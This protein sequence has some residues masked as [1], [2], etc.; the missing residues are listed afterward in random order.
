V[1]LPAPP[2][3]R[4]GLHFGVLGFPVRI[5]VSFVVVMALLGV[6]GPTTVPRVVLWVLIGAVSVLAHELGH[7]VVARTTGARPVIDLH[8][9]GGVTTF[10][11]PGPLS[12]GRSLAISVAGPLVGIAVG[13][14]LLV[15]VPRDAAG[16]SLTGYALD[17]AVFVNLGW[18]VLNL[19][20]I[21]PLDGGHA[22]AEL[23]PGDPEA[24]VRRAAFVSVPVA[25]AV[26]LF[27]LHEDYLFGALLAG[28]FAFDNVRT[29]AATNRAAA[30]PFPP[31]IGSTP[32]AREV[33]WLVD[34][35]RPDQA[36]HLL[37]TLP[38]DRPVDVAVHGLVLALTGR[39]EQGAPL[40]RHAHAQAP[41]DP[42]RTAVL[43][44]LLAAER[45]WDALGDLLDRV[46]HAG[47]AGGADGAAAPEVVPPEVV[48]AAQAAAAR[49]G[50]ARAAARL[51]GHLRGEPRPAA[52][53]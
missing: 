40:V 48:A 12:R 26:A 53:P 21:L 4:S 32:A 44:R 42:L 7:A 52:S 23:L 29:L 15:L 16:G 13:L 51:A 30:E 50:A 8:S 20:P 41:D 33:L 10:S 9:F 3:G 17:A 38:A 22:L 18:G 31:P 49:A 35:G 37:A 45:D 1:T 14:A 34:Q 24:R 39:V 11:P 46:G 27:A 2:A 6:A 25:A 47:A 5:H 19:L 36:K 28:W 43:A